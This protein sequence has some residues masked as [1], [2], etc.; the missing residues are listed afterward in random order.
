MRGSVRSFAAALTPL[1]LACASPVHLAPPAPAPP[2]AVTVAPEWR[3]FDTTDWTPTARLRLGGDV[4]LAGARGERWIHQAGGA[5][6]AASTM[7]PDDVTGV[8]RRADGYLF[9]GVTG[10]V[11][12][13]R[14]PLGPALE[15]RAP[16]IPIARAA[17][18]SRAIVAITP[19]GQLVRSGD[20]GLTW[21]KRAIDFGPR[22]PAALAMSDDGEGVLVAYPQLVFT[23][24]D[25]GERWTSDDRWGGFGPRAMRALYLGET[26]A[27]RSGGSGCDG[28]RRQGCD[29]LA[30]P[31]SR[32]PL[33]ATW[34]S[35]AVAG[36]VALA[37]D[38]W[39]LLGREGADEWR[40]GSA[41]FGTL[42]ELRD[43]PRLR[44][45]SELAL[46]ALADDVAIACPAR[47]H[48]E[49]PDDSI[50]L[51]SHDG[52]RKFALTQLDAF[53][54]PAAVDV[55]PGGLIAIRSRGRQFLRVRAGEPFRQREHAWETAA[56][57][58]RGGLFGLV[59]R[60]GARHLRALP[61]GRVGLAIVPSH[62][63][64]LDLDDDGA[65][66]LAAYEG[67]G[68]RILRSRDGGD[69]LT[70]I[71]RVEVA[72]RIALH[73]AFGVAT[74]R[75]ET[76]ETIDGG[77]TWRAIASP[78]GRVEACGRLGCLF[79]R[80]VRLGFGDPPWRGE[81]PPPVP[82]PA[83]DVRPPTA[84]RAKGSWSP[85]KT[86]LPTARDVAPGIRTI[87]L[88]PGPND[89]STVLVTRVGGS[90]PGLPAM[91]DRH[92]LFG[93]C[94]PAKRATT[95]TQVEYCDGG[96]WGYRSDETATEI[97]WFDPW[98]G[99]VQRARTT[100][101]EKMPGSLAAITPE[102]VLIWRHEFGPGAWW[103]GA[104]GQVSQV[105]LP[106]A[107]H[108]ERAPRA[109]PIR[110][111]EETWLVDFHR[112]P[113]ELES[114][115]MRGPPSTP[116]PELSLTPSVGSDDFQ[117]L[118]AL[119]DASPAYERATFSIARAPTPT[120]VF[121]APAL[122]GG[123][124]FLLPLFGRDA[125]RRLPFIQEPRLGSLPACAETPA[126][127][128]LERSGDG[129][130]LVASIDGDLKRFEGAQAVVFVDDGD[131]VC[132]SGLDAQHWP[133]ARP[134][135]AAAYF[136]SIDARAPSAGMVYRLH[137]QTIDERPLDCGA[138][139]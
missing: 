15:V 65:I 93:P 12:R 111:W 46:G 97:A 37:G 85:R 73:G 124:T 131:R 43:E 64:V 42:P 40:I 88:E 86:W 1:V 52:G 95:T 59:E 122:D 5:W 50:V 11:M 44:G 137:E 24:R 36:R 117:R 2:T 107:R 138:T 134:L 58:P 125:L 18:G 104:N 118:I 101:F 75:G 38:R 127:S 94:P 41:A 72:D 106:K 92:A 4:L 84:C 109:V 6:V 82:L 98:A 13:T 105:S 35:I 123:R 30:P 99:K 60:D 63:S 116:G 89:A 39:V 112:G 31:M 29:G 54:S 83:R 19:E 56:G 69:S 33:D 3:L 66:T 9:V 71:G 126:G 16:S 91:P 61:D 100:A 45:C 68:A 108:R 79:E 113:A 128:R 17:G 121:D 8:L 129:P 132:L 32:R 81:P 78:A 74:A 115:W 10:L 23:S 34:R 87:A 67:D 119:G 139:P 57:A 51:E 135:G 70:Q 102:G 110:A 7:L 114:R 21:S 26:G 80:G 103:I 20:A 76:R 48:G 130:T 49:A 62:S 96:V 77:Q 53:G 28:P 120:I 90:K 22:T 14:E 25:D 47:R 136:A 27:P 55:G 133:V